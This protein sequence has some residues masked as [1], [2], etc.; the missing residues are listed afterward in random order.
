MHTV[1]RH[2][3][4]TIPKRPSSPNRLLDQKS[5]PC[6]PRP[7]TW[8]LPA[9]PAHTLQLLL[10]LLVD[11]AVL[12]PPFAQFLH[13]QSRND[14]QCRRLELGATVMHRNV[15]CNTHL[16]DEIQVFLIAVIDLAY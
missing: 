14:S 3:C 9:H 15:R 4:L 16:R 11:L 1:Q 5:L 13:P 10:Q 12:R 6:D 8:S 2:I 7:S